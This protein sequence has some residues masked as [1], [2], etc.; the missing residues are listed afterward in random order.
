MRLCCDRLK[1]LEACIRCK[2]MAYRNTQ[3]LLQLAHKLYVCGKDERL[4]EGQ[5]LVY[6]AEAALEVQLNNLP[7]TV[8][9]V[10]GTIL[11]FHVLLVKYHYRPKNPLFWHVWHLS[12]HY[13]VHNCPPLFPVLN[14]MSP[15][16]I[17][18]LDFCQHLALHDTKLITV[19]EI[20]KIY[21]H[22]KIPH[23]FMHTLYIHTEK[24]P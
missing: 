11:L 22:L 15:M 4:Q 21:R 12:V 5:V 10:K 19:H 7:I 9:D 14:S 13:C 1:L 8:W 20:H 18:A 24:P 6:I 3:R 16:H 2:S 17:L 23:F